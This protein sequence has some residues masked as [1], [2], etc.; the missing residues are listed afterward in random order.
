MRHEAEEGKQSRISRLRDHG[1]GDSHNLLVQQH[2]APTHT[3]SCT[4]V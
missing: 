4:T 2:S 3:T 1:V